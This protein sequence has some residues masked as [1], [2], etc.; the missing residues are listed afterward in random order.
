MKAV[1]I[2]NAKFCKHADNIPPAQLY[3]FSDNR[4]QLQYQLGLKLQFIEASTL[5]EIEAAYQR[6]EADIFFVR[7]AWQEDAGDV[8]RVMKELRIKHPNALVIFIDPFDQTSSRFFGV[9][10][11]VDRFL[12][13]Q[14]LK[15]VTQYKAS[16][17]GGTVLT[18]TLA[19]E[20]GYDLKDWHVGSKVPEGYEHRIE[21][22]WFLT[23]TKKFKDSLF[24]PAMPWERWRKRDIDVFCHVSYGPR[25]NL[26][27][28]GQHR[29]VA[30]DILNQ[31][32]PDY[33][34]SVSGDYTGERKK[35]SSRQYFRDIKRSR[36]AV[37][38]FGWGEITWRDYEAV[39]YGCLLIKPS[40]E[41]IEVEPNIFSPGETYVPV[42]WDYSD[43]EE[44]CRYYLQHPD[45]ANE[46]V[47]NARQAYM[48]YFKQNQFVRK[49][50][51]LIQSRSD[52]PTELSNM[53]SLP[54]V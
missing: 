11:Y 42:R 27:W 23:V 33:Q 12:K 14:C 16:L 51:Q 40:V 38:P 37:S 20:Q 19:R 36:I 53:A 32:A 25:N 30:I 18:D 4:Q 24:R 46:I 47:R 31:L 26:E 1:V 6:A 22:G 8:E 49:I 41:H 35:V 15:D 43:L 28:Y 2:G 52:A 10:P 3:P 44:K 5:A 9:L 7:P 45:E 54:I 34:L 13:Y 29:K 50:E 48:N 17:L 21:T 39:C